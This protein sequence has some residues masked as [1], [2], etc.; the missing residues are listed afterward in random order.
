MQ[1]PPAARQFVTQLL[2]WGGSLL[3]HGSMLLWLA[4]VPLTQ[5]WETKFAGQRRTV[6][7]SAT[8]APPVELS[9]PEPVEISSETDDATQATIDTPPDADIAKT[10]PDI[11][12]IRPEA[13]L[14]VEQQRTPPTALAERREF[15]KNE[16]TTQEP[17]R[18]VPRRQRTFDMSPLA[19][20]TPVPLGSDEEEPPDF[21]MNPPPQYP[22]EAVRRGWEGTVLLRLQIASDG[23]VTRVEVAESSGY[24]VLDEAALRAVRLWKGIPA[25]RGGQAV[26]VERLLPVRFRR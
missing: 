7:V 12:V 6:S 16:R 17:P 10:S 19:A 18:Q 3:L 24:T 8:F 25:T 11:Q 14:Q 2:V 4:W 21:S 1:T 15:Q 20:A 5:A 13:E 9:E 22:P 26:A 23:R